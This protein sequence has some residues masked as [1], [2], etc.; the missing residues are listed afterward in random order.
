MDH[1][2]GAPARRKPEEQSVPAK[3]ADE[4]ERGM[5]DDPLEIPEFLLVPADV[6]RQ[7]WIDNPPRQMPFV[8]KPREENAAA[9]AFRARPL[10]ANGG[11]PPIIVWETVLDDWVATGGWDESRLGPPPG[12][13]GCR[14]PADILARYTLPTGQPTYGPRGPNGDIYAA[15]GPCLEK[16]ANAELDAAAQNADDQAA[17][18][19]LAELSELAYQKRRI[20][21]ARALR[22]PAA[23]LDKMVRRRRDELEAESPP[24][25][26][27]H[28]DVEPWEEPV[29]G[30]ALLY[31]FAA[32]VRRHVIMGED[33]V[34][35]VALWIMLT[36]V[37]ERAAVHSPLLLATS[38]E[39]NSGKSTLLGV[40]GFLV[41]RALLSV[42]ITGP[43]LFRSI[44]RWQPTFVID[45]AARLWL[46]TRISEKSLIQGGPAARPPSGVTR[47][48]T[49]RVRTRPSARRRLA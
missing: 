34:A 20:D 11:Y 43:A 32:R 48:R 46:T 41:R 27:P 31:E 5:I 45:E 16:K 8:A 1:L 14:A 13:D 6:R 28:W 42:S 9:A 29:D 21:E 15:T 36:W 17:I 4:R 38:A 35:A 37:H 25:L 23:A 47:R 39:A 18:N 24:P 44:D 7:A 30:A 19:K 3:A 12:H 10:G 40:I 33:Q 2:T 22:I 49:S 26:Y